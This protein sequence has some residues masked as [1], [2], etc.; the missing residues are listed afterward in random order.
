MRA[1]AAPAPDPAQGTLFA[2]EPLVSESGTSRVDAAPLLATLAD[3]AERGWIRRLDAALVRFMAAMGSDMPAPAVLAIAMTAH[4]EGRGHACLSIDELVTAPEPLLGWKPEARA[5]FTAVMATMPADPAQWLLALAACHNVCAD[6]LAPDDARPLVLRQGRLYLRRYWD[7]ECRVARQ[8]TRRAAVVEAV[9]E[10]QGRLWLDRLF[11]E[12]PAGSAPDWQ[13]IACALALRGRLTLITGG[14]GTGKTYTAARLLAL[15]FAMAPEGRPLRFA[16]AAP[17][18]KAAARL[19]QSIDAA[20]D[21]LQQRLGEALPLG[22]LASSL[23]AARTLHSLLGARPETRRFRHDAAHPLEVDVLVVDEASMVH[24]EMMAS[25]LD[26]LPPAARIVLLG[27]KDQLASVEAGAVLGELCR[28]ADSGRYTADTVRYVAALTGQHLPAPC[29][30]DAGPALSQRTA[31]LRESQRFGSAI[32]ALAQ[33]VNA[34]DAVLAKDLLSEDRSG[35]VCAMPSASPA[36]VVELA[37]SGRSGSPGGYRSYLEAIAARPADADAEETLA[38]AR[39]VLS[40]WDRFRVLCA[41][42]EGDWGVAGLNRA[43]EKR[44]REEG[45]LSGGAEWYEGRPVIVTRNERALGV[46][47]GDIGIA[48]RPT[49]DASTLRAYFIDGD[50]VRSVAVSRLADVETAFAM[51]VHK[52]QGSEFDHTVLVLPAEAGMVSSRELIYTGITRARSALTLVSK[53]PAAFFEGIAQTARRSSG[54]HD[55][56]RAE[57]GASLRQAPSRS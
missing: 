18:G 43:I 9:D 34:G 26:A 7:Y 6:E 20:L 38:W 36:D 3:W 10:A 2:D 24:L 46:Y 13:K 49:A 33:A 1:R 45:L 51:T 25:L 14:P 41:V 19:K 31:M 5:S 42:R 11:A 52:S 53:S 8:V 12:R 37:A 30:D 48:L 57:S 40:E 54:L 17:T 32:G 50:A 4:M 39:R 21:G 23:A 56:L 27:D 29:L 35:P 22:G 55:L 16:L 15:L 47:N 44:L 28:D